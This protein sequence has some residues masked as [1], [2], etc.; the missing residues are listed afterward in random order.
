MHNF[1]FS[2]TPPPDEVIPDSAPIGL[3]VEDFS[4]PNTGGVAVLDMQNNHIVATDSFACGIR[5]REPVGREEHLL[6]FARVAETNYVRAQGEA[7]HVFLGSVRQ[8]DDDGEQVWL[9]EPGPDF[10]AK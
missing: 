2:K 5:L 1:N 4:S 8:E 9:D 3:F 10:S 7:A 6:D